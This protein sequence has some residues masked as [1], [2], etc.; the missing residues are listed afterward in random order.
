MKLD[1]IGDVHGK[2][3]ALTDLLT[4]LGYENLSGV[5]RHPAGRKAVFVGD[6]VDRGPYVSEVLA[7]VKAM[8]DA[9]EAQVL[10]GNHEYG[11]LAWYTQNADGSFRRKHHKRYLTYMGPS[12]ALFDHFPEEHAVYLDWFKRLPLALEL[13]GARFVHAY[14]DEKTV[15]KITPGASLH[16]LGWSEPHFS[17]SKKDMADLLT[18]GPELHLP[19][20]LL[21]RDHQG[22]THAQARINWW[23]SETAH[24]LRALIK[25]D[26]P[27]LA[28]IAVPEKARNYPPPRPT[29]PPTFFGHF[30]FHECP[31]LLGPNFTSVD[32]TGPHGASIGAYRWDGEGILNEDKL[33][34]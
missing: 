7:L 24:D 25:P 4:R 33:V 14:W 29:D 18:K 5:W 8:A 2:R 9:G 34:K 22:N 28:G 1:I 16:D 6:L 32:F 10:L 21:V 23:L 19:E 31:G 3:T 26:T 15:A 20:G 11:L 17:G 13:G 12:I 30:G 27:E